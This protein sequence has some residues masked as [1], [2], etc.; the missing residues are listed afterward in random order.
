[1][2]PLGVLASRRPVASGGGPPAFLYA[3]G[4]LSAA[5]T[6]TFTVDIGTEFPGRTLYIMSFAWNSADRTITVNGDVATIDAHPAAVDNGRYQFCRAQPTGATASIVLGSSS[7][8]ARWGLGVWI[9]G[10]MDFVGA[11]SGTTSATVTGVTGGIIIAGQYGS[12]L[13]SSPTWTNADQRFS[14]IVEGARRLNGAD[15]TA[16]GATTV[17][18]DYGGAFASFAAASYEPA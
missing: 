18:T 2:I 13:T 16:S 17:S 15:T 14:E 4:R 9:G 3:E 7:I 8:I 5:L 12:A 10:P 1:M 11:S 6:T